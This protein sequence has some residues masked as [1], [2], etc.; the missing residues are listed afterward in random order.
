M[1][2]CSRC[3][4]LGPNAPNKWGGRPLASSKACNRPTSLS[5]LSLSRS[6]LLGPLPAFTAAQIKYFSVVIMSKRFNLW[7]KNKSEVI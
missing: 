1:L 5:S 6:A 4:I 2:R 7:Y 3:C